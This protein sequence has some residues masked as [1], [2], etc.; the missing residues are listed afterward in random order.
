[1]RRL[2][3]W[4]RYIKKADN[5][6]L[7]AELERLHDERLLVPVEYDPMRRCLRRMAKAC[8]IEL[9]RREA[10]NSSNLYLPFKEF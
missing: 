5:G 8:L 7:K 2:T 4:K 6:T 9:D 3:A 1:M 10:V